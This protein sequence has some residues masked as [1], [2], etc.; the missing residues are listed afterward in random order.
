M[1]VLRPCALWAPPVSGTSASA[2]DL[3]E[4]RDARCQGVDP[5]NGSPTMAGQSKIGMP[6]SRSGAASQ[7]RLVLQGVRCR[8]PDNLAGVPDRR[9]PSRQLGDDSREMVLPFFFVKKGMSCTR[10]ILLIDKCLLNFGLLHYNP[11]RSRLQI[12]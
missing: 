9:L 8:S 12:Y 10:I 11:G 1:R 4:G 2:G 5:T 6:V 7:Q 3:E